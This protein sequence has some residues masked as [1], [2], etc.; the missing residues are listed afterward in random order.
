MRIFWHGH[1]K[2]L[3]L[4]L[5]SWSA[6]GGWK[7]ACFL[8]RKQTFYLLFLG[9]WRNAYVGGHLVCYGKRCYEDNCQQSTA[10][11]TTAT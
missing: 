9:F 3:R 10:Q 6:Y 11:R 4:R 1:Q 5:S 8:P 2:T 7:W